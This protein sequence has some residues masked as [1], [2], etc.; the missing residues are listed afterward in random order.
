MDLRTRIRS[1]ARQFASP[2]LFLISRRVP[3]DMEHL[4]FSIS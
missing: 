2:V 4:R 3:S 1:R